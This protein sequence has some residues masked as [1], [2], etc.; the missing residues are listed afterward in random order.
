MLFL[1]L[2]VRMGCLYL[3]VVATVAN[4]VVILSVVEEDMN[5]EHFYCDHCGYEDFDV[6]VAF[7]GNYAERRFYICPSCGESSCH[8]F[9]YGEEYDYGD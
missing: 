6:F 3:R 2:N 4:R 9:I 7:D 1:V 5:L 8:V